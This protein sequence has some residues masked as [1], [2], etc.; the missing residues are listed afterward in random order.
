MGTGSVKVKD[1]QH[2]TLPG[3]GG[4]VIEA[5]ARRSQRTHPHQ[6]NFLQRKMKFTKEGPEVEDRFQEHKLVLGVSRAMAAVTY[7]V[8]RTGH[9]ANGNVGASHHRDFE[10]TACLSRDTKPTVDVSHFQLSTDFSFGI[11]FAVQC[12]PLFSHPPTL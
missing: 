1:I 7:D 3:R 10:T 2:S 8:P 6:K 4:A 12:T 5:M 11:A 9:F